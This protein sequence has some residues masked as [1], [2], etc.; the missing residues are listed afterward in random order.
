MVSP[1]PVLLLDSGSAAFH[2]VTFQDITGPLDC[3]A[4]HAYSGGILLES[5][6]F[7]KAPSLY[8]EHQI[9]LADSRSKVYGSASLIV[10]ESSPAS[11]AEALAPSPEDVSLTSPVTN[12][13]SHE[14]EHDHGSYE[15]EHSVHG[16]NEHHEHV[17]NRV[18]IVDLEAGDSVTPLDTPEAADHSPRF[19]SM[20][21][22]FLSLVQVHF[23]SL[24]VIHLSKCMQPLTLIK[25]ELVRLVMG[26][27][28]DL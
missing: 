24:F 8:H 9:C 22:V 4:M 10:D 20:D 1:S 11:G 13:G 16:D 26:L 21:S 18:W 25:C 5:S 3:T 14:H 15:H 27:I 7:M 6:T 23:R 17:S 2:G 12:S 28:S 19:L